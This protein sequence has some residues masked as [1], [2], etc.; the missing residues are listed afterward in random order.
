MAVHSF[1]LLPSA[2]SHVHVACWRQVVCANRAGAASI[3]IDETGESSKK[4]EGE[5]VP[6]HVVRSLHDALEVLQHKFQLAS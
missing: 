5:Q 2:C 4:L 1:P 6:T 3:L